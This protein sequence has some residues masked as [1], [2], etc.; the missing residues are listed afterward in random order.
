[1]LTARSPRLRCRQTYY[2][3]PY[4]DKRIANPEQRICEDIP[5]FCSGLAEL[6][7]EWV[8]ACV[9]GVFYAYMLRSYSGTSKYTAAIMGYVVGAGVATT[10]LAPGFGRLFKKEQDLEGAC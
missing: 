3:L 8:T 6:L 2:K 10:V 9:D 5:K 4:V 1:V 7:R